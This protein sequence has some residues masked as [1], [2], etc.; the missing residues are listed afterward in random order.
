[1]SSST[2]KAFAIEK[3][4]D[5]GLGYGI[6]GVT[7]DGNNV[8]EVYEAAEAAVARA[9]NGEGPTII[10]AITYRWKGHSRSDK[11]LYRTKEEIEEWKHKDPLPRFISIV[12][13]KGLLSQDEID[14]V[15]QQAH[16][17]IVHAVNEAVKAESA[18]P[19][20]LLDAVFKK[21]G[22]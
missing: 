4:A 14:A 6:P 11:N 12:L 13:E 20:G 19:S 17:Q 10:E 22:A 18:D 5:R 3:L 9:R 16:D 15:Q 2:E 8:V 21:V 1:M 7:V